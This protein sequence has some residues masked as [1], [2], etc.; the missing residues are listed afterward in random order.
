MAKLGSLDLP[1][2]WTEDWPQLRSVFSAGGI[3]HEAFRLV[4][5]KVGGLLLTLILITFGA[6]FWNDVLGLLVGLK[7]AAFKKA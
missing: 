3:T 1:L 6:P 2:G 7:T 5:K 4:F